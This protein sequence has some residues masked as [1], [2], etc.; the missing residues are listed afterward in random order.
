MAPTTTTPTTNNHL[1]VPPDFKKDIHLFRNFNYRRTLMF[2]LQFELSEANISCIFIRTF[3]EIGRS[4]WW[5]WDRQIS[6]TS[7]MQFP[8][9]G[10][11][12]PGRIKCMNNFRLSASEKT[13][14]FSQCNFPSAAPSVVL[15]L[16]FMA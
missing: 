5:W 14:I 9:N 15:L 13:I 12:V 1:S 3:D 6:C 16:I 7:P 10:V 8:I 11:N 2:I 4:W